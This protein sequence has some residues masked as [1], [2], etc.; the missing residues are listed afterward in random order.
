MTFFTEKQIAE[1][2]QNAQDKHEV[3]RLLN[4]LIIEVNN[5]G[6]VAQNENANAVLNGILSYL[7][8]KKEKC[9]YVTQNY[10]S[11]MDEY[12]RDRDRICR[13]FDDDFITKPET[14]EALTQLEE[15][16]KAR[17]QELE[18]QKSATRMSHI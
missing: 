4:A 1:M 9:D 3:E 14:Q 18:Q 11:I 7:T 8:G 5:K 16:Y 13:E 6:I 15:Q 2:T 10:S 17:M 12:N